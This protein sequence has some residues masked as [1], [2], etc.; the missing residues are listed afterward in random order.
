M[1]QPP[2]RGLAQ[3]AKYAKEDRVYFGKNRVTV[4]A[5]DAF[6]IAVHP[7]IEKLTSFFFANFASSRLK[8]LL[9][10]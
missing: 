3:A 10:C 4:F 6:S 1:Y 5:K 8:L 2:A 9:S 7:A